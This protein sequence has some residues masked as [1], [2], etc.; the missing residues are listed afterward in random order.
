MC[1]YEELGWRT[2]MVALCLAFNVVCALISEG[3]SAAFTD[4]ELRV[5]RG[6]RGD[7]HPPGPRRQIEKER[8]YRLARS[9]SVSTYR[10]APG[11]GIPG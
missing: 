1:T 8:G 3:L 5:Q 10:G 6:V 4:A 11:L 2:P 9:A 7:D